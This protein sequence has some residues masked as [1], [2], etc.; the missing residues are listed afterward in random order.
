MKCCICGTVKN[1]EQYLDNIFKNMEKIGSLFNDYVIILS[2]GNSIDNTTEK[3]KEYKKTNKRVEIFVIKEEVN[4]FRT[5]RIAFGRN[6]CLRLIRKKYSNYDF[7]IMMDCDDV[8]SPGINLPILK[9]YLNRKD[10]DSLSFN[11]DPYYDTWALSIS[12][13]FFSYRHWEQ[14]EQAWRNIFNKINKKFK[15]CKKDELVKCA[16]AFNGFAIYRTKKFI[17]C[18]YYGY[19]RLDLIPEEMIQMNI[20]SNGFKMFFSEEIGN[21]NTKWEDCEHRSFHMEAIKKNNAKIMISPE[22]LFN[23]IKF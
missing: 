15:E 5:Q 2:C 22:I 1:V 17:N 8:C 21:E 18:N 16:S 9:K 13:Y 20:E 6:I 23:T 19:P 4:P 11:K 7:F 12:P 14:E 10:W 3:I